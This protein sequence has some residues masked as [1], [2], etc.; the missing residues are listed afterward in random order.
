[1]AEPAA[2]TSSAALK[3]TP[4]H[5]FHLSAGA[6]MVEFA[7]WEMPLV[8]TGIVEEH[9]QCRNSGAFFDV[10]HMGRLRFAGKDAEKFLNMLVTR[11]V[12]KMKPGQSR[13]SFVCNERGGIMDDVI[14]ARHDHA[15]EWSMVCN[16]SNRPKIVGHF[17]RV[18]Q[19]NGF[20][21]VMDDVTEETAMC[22][23]QGPKVIEDVASLLNEAVD[24]D[25]RTLKKFGFSRGVFMD[26]RVEVYRSG[27]TG[28]DGV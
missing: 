9:H 5:D 28:E 21:V 6:R 13:Y 23:L 8:Y 7:G 26:S 27:Y 3:R 11:D 10:S 22:A 14:V 12:T 17:E 18:R 1:M 19:V 25:V 4:F 24:E 20:D 16:A 15:N 2:S